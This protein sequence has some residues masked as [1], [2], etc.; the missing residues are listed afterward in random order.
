MEKQGLTFKGNRKQFANFLEGLKE[1]VENE[2]AITLADAIAL[3]K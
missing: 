2:R 1:L 3:R